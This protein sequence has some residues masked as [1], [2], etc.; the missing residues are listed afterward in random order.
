[1]A[2]RQKSLDSDPIPSTLP[3]GAL[4]VAAPNKM[5]GISLHT[6]S[7]GNNTKTISILE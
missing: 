5:L 3:V 7:S 6:V 2:A 4:E 1:M